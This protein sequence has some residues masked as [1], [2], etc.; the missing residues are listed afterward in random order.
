LIP[1]G[2]V[3]VLVQSRCRARLVAGAV[4]LAGMC[5]LGV[6]PARAASC[7]LDLQGVVFGTYDT[8]SNQA[9]NGAGSITVTCDVFASYSL[10]LSPGNGTL[11][12]REL[13]SG[14]NTIFYNLY[15]DALHDII[16]GDGTGGTAL[17]NGSGTY[18]I[19]PIYGHVPAGQ[20]VPAGA[21]SDTVTITLIF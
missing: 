5:V 17:V 9:L 3:T 6:A 14:A 18:D 19:Y 10:A 20:N 7:T 13:Q 2:T 15:T 4:L 11:L 12:A 16:W 21:Y 1:G 8:L